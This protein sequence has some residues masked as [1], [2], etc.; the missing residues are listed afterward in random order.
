[1]ANH[2]ANEHE[3]VAAAQKGDAQAFTKLV[4]QYDRKIYRLGVNITGR[5]E[6]A[7]DVLQESF[8]KAYSKLHQFQGHSRFYT[9]LVRI[10]VNEALLK[11]RE[12]KHDRWVSLDEPAEDDDGHP[13]PHEIVEW[14]ENPA[15]EYRQQELAEILQREIAQLEPDYRI[16]FV[17][18]DVEQL[19]TQEA[20]K[21]L[22]LSVPALKSR[23]LRARL[24]LRERLNKYFR[25]EAGAGSH[26][27]SMS[28]APP[29]PPNTLLSRL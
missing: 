25:P 16:V 22:K 18:R 10:A 14:R 20:A 1:M 27:T 4:N 19:S 13:M 26:T 9:W 24:K 2:L 7:E 28:S 17:L 15:E 8:L 29:I 23:L 5:P 11:L 12:R 3:L 21:A 6:D